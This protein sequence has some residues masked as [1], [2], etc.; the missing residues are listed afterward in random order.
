LIPTPVSHE[1]LHCLI[2]REG[3]LTILAEVIVAPPALY[4]LLARETLNK[5]IAVAAQNVSDKKEGAY[6]GEICVAQVKDIGA[7]WVIIGHSE[8]RQMF[9]E[10]DAIV[11]SKTKFALE[12]G[13]SVL[14][15]C[16]ETLEER[17]AGKTVSVVESQLKA[18][19]DQVSDWSK[20]VVAYEP[21]W[22]VTSKRVNACHILTS[23]FSGPLELVKLQPLSKLKK[24]M[25]R[26]ANSSARSCLPL[27]QRAHES[28]TEEVLARRTARSWLSSQISMDSWLVVPV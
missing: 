12:G 7:T 5:N 13:L 2:L 24:C 9:H 4:L 20:I 11:A 18:V 27:L 28:C 26:S 8:R 21:I 23:L 15:C 16:G 17:E 14:L 19:V 25:L 1:L 10:T 22:Y 3:S 6:T